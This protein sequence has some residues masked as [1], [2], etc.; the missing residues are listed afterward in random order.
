MGDYFY[1]FRQDRQV[2]PSMDTFLKGTSHFLDFVRYTRCRYTRTGEPWGAREAILNV[3][4]PWDLMDDY[5]TDPLFFFLVN[6][7]LLSLQLFIG[8]AFA[9]GLVMD[10]Y[11]LVGEALQK[12][13]T[14][15]TVPLDP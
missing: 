2:S 9:S 7:L 10:S 5:V 13:E 4:F 3:P 8:Y 1:F 14:S 12:P 6:L 11:G 15:G